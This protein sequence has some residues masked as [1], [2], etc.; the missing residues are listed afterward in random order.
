[1]L[2]PYYI[3]IYFIKYAKCVIIFLVI[4]MRVYH[5]F[6][7]FFRKDS[8]VLILGSIPSRKS[9]EEGFYYAHPQNRFWKVLASVYKEDIPQTI[10]GKKKFLE[11]HNIA[12]W[13]VCESC[14]IHASSD[15]SIRDVRVNDLSRVLDNSCVEFIFTTGRKAYDL[16]NKYSKEKTKIDAVYLPSTS[17]ANARASF[18]DL[19][20]E[21]SKIKDVIS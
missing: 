2:P 19:V 4:N 12:L 16:Y 20:I 17:A 14:L 18:Q 10:E 13:D 9:R 6:D 7:A 8:K 1:M 3:I 21:Y 5:E 15:E 11:K